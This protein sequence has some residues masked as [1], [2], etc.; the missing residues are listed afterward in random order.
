M[1]TTTTHSPTTPSEPKSLW[2]N[3]NF[4][5][6]LSGQGISLTGTQITQVTLPLLLLSLTNSP[7]VAGLITA[8]G[9]LSL[10]LFCLPAG[11]LVDRWNRKKV[12]LICDALSTLGLVSLAL[13]LLLNHLTLV[14]V[15]IVAFFNESL[16]IFFSLAATAAMPAVIAKKQIPQALSINET[17]TST[18]GTVGPTLGPLLFSLGRAVPYLADALSTALSVMSLLFIRAQFQEERSGQ[19][20]GALWHDI[21]EG[22][23]WLWQ[24]KLI[25]F[26]AL[27]TFGLMAPCSGYLLI[28]AVMA[29]EVHASEAA[30]GLILGSG[31]IGSIIG[32]LLAGPLYRR[33]GLTRMIVGSVWIW[34]LSWL[35]F[36]FAHDPIM[37]GVANAG[38]FVIVPIYMVQQLSVRTALTPDH[39]RGRIN[40]VFRL[41]AFGSQPIGLAING[42]LLQYVG[43]YY[44]VAILFVPQIIL[45]I[46]ILFKIKFLRQ[47]ETMINA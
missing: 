22:M 45:A 7:A 24:H 29:R 27:T 38:G 13:A 30:L 20:P 33:F 44:T 37:L 11:A 46:G 36:A 47:M 39:L 3:V 10:L 41:I 26:L 8:I 12:M 31:G 35:L 28:I 42:L 17:V 1:S 16:G 25:R 5:I 34:A 40:A 9:S 19:P 4:L 43:P 15:A 23:L 6:L 14:H 21:R 32:A 18:A 2:R